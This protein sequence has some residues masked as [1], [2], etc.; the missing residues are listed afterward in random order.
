MK[1]ISLY[2]I[3]ICNIIRNTRFW[4][5]N[6]NILTTRYGTKIIFKIINEKRKRLQNPPPA[7][8][9]ER[10]RVSG[11][12][13]LWGDSSCVQGQLLSWAIPSDRKYLKNDFSP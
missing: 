6:N 3:L 5:K 2:V 8:V 12:V 13:Y 7:G 9:E 1:I 10:P 4:V 11:N